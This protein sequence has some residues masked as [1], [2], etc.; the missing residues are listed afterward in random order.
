MLLKT[1]LKFILMGREAMLN[2]KDKLFWK[3]VEIDKAIVKTWPKWMQQIVIT[4]RTCN[5][6]R[7]LN[8]QKE[9]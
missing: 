7:F 1:L 5:T 4:A 3:Q 9:K 6:G 2:K 8:V